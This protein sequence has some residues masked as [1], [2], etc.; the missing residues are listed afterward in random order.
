MLERFGVGGVSAMKLIR[1]FLLAFVLAIGSAHA[2]STDLPVNGVATWCWSGSAWVGCSSTGGGS[3]VSVTSSTLTVSPSPGTGTFTIN[4]PAG[5]S[6]SGTTFITASTPTVP[7]TYS[8]ALFDPTSNTITASIQACNQGTGKVWDQ[9]F[10][11]ATGQSAVHIITLTPSAGTIDGSASAQIGSAY[12][13]LHIH[14]NGG[15]CVIL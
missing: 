12:G 14:S 13:A 9:W 6:D 2:Q 4:L 11:D 7:G 10:K 3:S 15:A 5:S 1:W 8:I